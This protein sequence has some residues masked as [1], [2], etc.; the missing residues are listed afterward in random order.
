MIRHSLTKSIVGAAWLRN[1]LIANS[2]GSYSKAI[3][4]EPLSSGL[5]E[6]N[7]D[8]PTAE[9]L[10]A[11]V[12]DL[13]G[14]LPNSFTGQILTARSKTSHAEV[15][16]FRTR[17]YVFEQVQ[18]PSSYSHVEAIL[19]ELKFNTQ[20]LTRSGWDEILFSLLGPGPT[21]GRLP[22]LKW[23]KEFIQSGS[24]SIQ[25]LSLTELPQLTW[26]GCFQPI[27]ESQNEFVL[28]IK[29]S[30]PDR[31][32]VRKKLET[33]R[34]VSHALSVTSSLELRNI[35][36][37]SVLQS[38]EETLERILVGKETL[39]EISLAIVVKG[40]KELSVNLA[41]ELERLTS[42]IGNAGLF[43]EGVGS[44]PVLKSHIPGN[45]PLGIR[46]IAILSGN[47]THLLPLL[48]DYSRSNDTSSLPLRSR[49]GE[50]SNLNLFSRANLNF[51]GFICG[52]SGSGKSFLMNAILNSALKDNPRT[53][54]CIF[55]VGGSYRK[56][57]EAAGGRS[58]ALLPEEAHSLIS[59][60]LKRFPVSK[61]GFFRSFLETLCG[62]GN[63]ITHSHLVA[64]D[65]LLKEIEG[66][67][68]SI[69][70]LI[71][72]AQ[73]RS[74]RF[75]LDIAHW[76]KPH[77]SFDEIPNRPDLIDLLKSQ[78]TALDFKELDG[79]PT[80]QRAT[81]LLIVD[82][83]WKDLLHGKY[84]ETR[85][86]FDEVWRFFTQCKGFLEEFYRTLRK[87]KGSIISITQNLA[88]YGDDS[89]AK[90][91]FTNS[92]TKIFLQN[93]ASAEYLRETFDLPE[94]DVERALSVTSN[95]P[96][97][98]EFFALTPTMSQ[99]FRLYPT[100]EFYDLANTENI[101]GQKETL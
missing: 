5:L 35:E 91:L 76:L 52:S 30:I 94:T 53:R 95:K 23:E 2:D 47:L 45:R 65:D 32:K 85:I 57:V 12:N 51:N 1:G 96:H 25:V 56:F 80:L 20:A 83:I 13:I 98:S 54:I 29:I 34:R 49:T 3:E 79:D 67:T 41:R 37:N 60:N 82:L 7:C 59:T 70:M 89:F 36:S 74:E 14:K 40:S 22:D 81:I 10:F 101:A 42:G 62:S 61:D 75:Y 87:Y 58:I 31:S 17:L 39:F 43:M 93:G 92:F 55:D 19:E 100:K 8:G 66:K 86:V 90:M 28:S 15:P 99:I 48:H 88:D 38:S 9:N 26:K 50:E 16:G 63:H 44:L 21:E 71:S 72:N 69:R 18:N 97:Y 68:L 24:E 73:K 78:T 11:K 4:T 33:K 64:I 6:E 27:F 77:V 84:T 46:T